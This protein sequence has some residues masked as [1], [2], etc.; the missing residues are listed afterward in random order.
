MPE[1]QQ[2]LSLVIPLY[3]E[4]TNIIK[5]IKPILKEFENKGITH[6]LVLV[7]NGSRDK[8]GEL[9]K[10]LAKEYSTLTIVTVDLNQGYGYG[11]LKGMDK[12]S[13]EY[14]GFMC[15][16]GQILPSDILNIYQKLINESLDLCKATRVIRQDGLRRKF[17]SF[18]YNLIFSL[19]FISVKSR[20]INATP[21]IMRRE[22]YQK[23][24]LKS[25]DW[26]IDAEV[27]LK[28][29][30]LGCRVAEVPVT[31]YCR[32]EGVSNV[33]FS[34]VFEFLKNIFKYKIKGLNW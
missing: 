19:L 12:A 33:R 15:G 28:C 25:K 26:F 22:I 2:K 34:T 17:I 13:G 27:M 18:F 1:V 14:I 23:L 24:H 20:D 29:K 8:T 7:D 10:A 5:V 3:N 6:E 30:E 4:E 31:F 9:I 21:K 16:D 32:Q 11:I